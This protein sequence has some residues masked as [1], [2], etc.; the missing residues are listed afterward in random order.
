M[1]EYPYSGEVRYHKPFLSI[2]EI[3][4]SI[5]SIEPIA[6]DGT[7]EPVISVEQRGGDRYVPI[8]ITEW[9]DTHMVTHLLSISGIDGLDNR[10]IPIS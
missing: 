10:P 8:A 4:A 5:D 6:V 7:I 3:E 1:G 9:V 2:I